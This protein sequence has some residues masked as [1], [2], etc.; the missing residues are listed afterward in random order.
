MTL[1]DWLD[2]LPDAEQMRATDRWAIEEQG[3]PSLQL[4]ERAGRGLAALVEEVGPTGR[5]AILCGGGNNGGDGFVAARLLR[6]AGRDVVVAVTTDLAKYEG[7]AKAN[8]DLLEERPRPFDPSILDGAAVA[9]DAL[10]G[11]GFSG[12]VREPVRSA[13][14]ALNAADLPVVAC[15][16]PSG[17]DASTGEVAGPAVRAVAT[18][19]FHA[20]KPGLW[21]APG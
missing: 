6:E 9:V 14:E 18:G 21:V 15:D 20:A 1:P 2:P 16:V 11:T 10:L 13:V 8:L 19:T 5:V 17:V 4:M 12:E 7:D 3:V